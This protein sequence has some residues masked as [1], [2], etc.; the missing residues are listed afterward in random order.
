[1]SILKHHLTHMAANDLTNGYTWLH[2]SFGS[3]ACRIPLTKLGT[4][5]HSAIQNLQNCISSA[6]D[7]PRTASVELRNP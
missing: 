3:V 4:K 7:E 1:M 5:K 6:K 2:V